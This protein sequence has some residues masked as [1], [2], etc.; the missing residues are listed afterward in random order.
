MNWTDSFSPWMGL[1]AVFL[2]SAGVSRGL[3]LLSDWHDHLHDHD[4]S[5]P[6]KM[7]EHPVPRVGGI[8]IFAGTLLGLLGLGQVLGESSHAW[9]MG[10]GLAAL[11]AFGSGIWEDLT[12]QVSPRQRLVFAALSATLAFAWAGARVDHAGLPGLD[13]LLAL[14]PVAVLFTLFCVAGMVNAVN[15]IDGFNGLASMVCC[16]MLAALAYV[17]WRADDLLVTGMAL[18]IL[19]STLGFFI[20]NFPRGRIFLGDGG[21]YFLGFAVAALAAMLTHRN[22]EVAG[23]LPLAVVAYPVFEL[24]FSMYRRKFIHRTSLTAPDAGHLHTL[25]YRRAVLQGM[26]A[27]S[28]KVTQNS[29]TSP[30]LWFLCGVWLLPSALFWDNQL[31]QALSILG[32]CLS[33]LAMYRQIVGYRLR[34]GHGIPEHPSTSAGSGPSSVAPEL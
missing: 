29:A 17:G 4:L 33:Y 23:L 2:L 14:L 10:F 24:A 18:S 7:H 11:P 1:V 25:I 13:A 15:I 20:W 19:A 8:G 31:I 5:G 6:Q 32:L 16:F 27:R 28:P 21:A 22:H 34:P 30:Y 12:K 3:I 26:F 9:L